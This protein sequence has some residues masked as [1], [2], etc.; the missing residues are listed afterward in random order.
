M[1]FRL[2]ALSRALAPLFAASLVLLSA[3]PGFAQEEENRRLDGVKAALDQSETEL[4]ATTFDDK[5]LVDLT[6][7]VDAARADIA[8]VQQVL[9]PRQQAITTRLQQLGDKPAEGAPAE[10]AE[11]TQERE[12]QLALRKPIDETLKRAGLLLVQ[13]DQIV[14]QISGKRRDLFTSRFLTQ[15]RSLLAPGLWAAVFNEMPRRFAAA[16]SFL[17]QWG[18]LFVQ[19]LTPGTGGVLAGSVLLAILLGWPIARWSRRIGQRYAIEQVD[20]GGRLK[21][22]LAAVW[23]VLITAAAPVAAAFV[24]YQGLTGAGFVPER[25]VA[26]LSRL[27]VLT[28]V[29][30]VIAGLTRAILSP[31][32]PSWRLV[33]VSDA[34]AQRLARYPLWIAGIYAVT[35]AVQV[36]FDIIGVGLAPT[37]AFDGISALV[38][39]F[40]IGLALRPAKQAAAEA[41][42]TEA[43]ASSDSAP[44]DGWL[45]GT[46]RVALWIALGAV[47]ISVVTGYVAFAFFLIQQIIWLGVL[48][49]VL[50]ILLEL[51][52]NLCGS[53]PGSRVGRFARGTIGIR[54]ER[55]D[56]ICALLSGFLKLFLVVVAILLAAAPWGIQSGDAFGWFSRALAGFQLGGLSLSPGAILGAIAFLGGGILLTRAVQRWLDK[57]YLPHTRI[58]EG[59]K[60]SIRTATGYTG[61]IVAAA[62][63]VSSLGIG[64]DKFA[65][66]AGALSVGIGFGLQSVVS[67]FVSGLILL[68]ERPVKVGDWIGIGTSE[69]NVRRISVRSTLIELFDKS[70][71][72]V[73]NSD[74]ITKPV[75]NRTHQNPLGRVQLNLGTG[76][77]DS[78]QEVRSILLQALSSHP[79]VLSNPA[80]QVLIV[81][82]TDAGIQWRV[83]CFVATP[84]QVQVTGSD[85]Y[86]D[87]LTQLQS[88]GLTITASPS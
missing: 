68:A 48:G 66:V 59:L 49:A 41:V 47:L 23:V 70:T 43:V 8:E 75:L 76:H 7:R 81:A 32:R 51:A 54:T 12:A 62:L 25:A 82:T 11:L 14:E 35:R 87:I 30:S 46:V 65:I 85:L 26:F 84:R 71:L 22:C 16:S 9:T 17:Q 69:G 38:I 27:V 55:F 3:L 78:V 13:S 53:G 80:P 33:A 39:A 73:P 64:L 44:E 34:T 79:T 50:Y 58:D 56:Q 63:A 83:R 19:R 24:L 86:L 61:I 20:G 45:M 72:I 29:V 1:L 5:G 6:S 4:G 2:P 40:V 15:T 42:D 36:F 67:N 10:S 21:R 88:K 31:K 52:D 28:A 60:N 74:L 37:V 18:N 77:A 57:S